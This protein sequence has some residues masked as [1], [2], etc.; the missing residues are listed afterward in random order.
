MVVRADIWRKSDNV[1]LCQLTSSDEHFNLAR[2][3]VKVRDRAG[4]GTV[5]MVVEVDRLQTLP[6][7][8]IGKYVDHLAISEMH[9]VDAGLRLW[10]NL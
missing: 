4:A 10:L 1:T 2:T 5:E 7:T 6:I 3:R 9:A 8:R